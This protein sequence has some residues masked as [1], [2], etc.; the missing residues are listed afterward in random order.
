MIVITDATKLYRMGGEEIRALDGLSLTI[1]KGDFFALVGPSGSGKSTL[2]NV[3]GALDDIDSGMVLVEGTDI[4]KIKDSEKAAYRR[5]RIGFVFQTFN[6]QR[7]LTALENVELPL[8]FEGLPAKERKEKASMA[9]ETVQLSD[10]I[11]HRPNELSGGQQQRVAIAR[12]I[13]ND[14]DV[15]LADEPTGNLDSKTGLDIMKLLKELNDKKNVT[16]LMVT[17]N[18]EHADFADRV[19][20]MRDGKIVNGR[21]TK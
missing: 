4:S 17:H 16:V 6:L 13:V 10:R 14:P 11:T 21:E 20:H 1:E 5:N 7:R 15:L 18:Q 19:L 8:I 12:A 3:V 9:L 2:M